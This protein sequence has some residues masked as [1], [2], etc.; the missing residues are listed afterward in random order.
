MKDNRKKHDIINIWPRG[1]IYLF[2]YVIVIL[3]ILIAITLPVCLLINNEP[4]ILFDFFYIKEGY[5]QFLIFLPMS[6]FL[7][8][9]FI[10][11][12]IFKFKVTFTETHICVPKISEIQERKLKVECCQILSC[13]TIM[14]GFFNYYFEFNCLDGKT[15][16]ISIIRFSFKQLEEVLT[17]IQERGGLPNQDIYEILNMLRIKKNKRKL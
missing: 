17:L 4:M 3:L 6:V 16:K 13:K 9:I 15:R 10:S 5:I 1:T 2:I 8:Y 7:I 14:E 12:G 11:T